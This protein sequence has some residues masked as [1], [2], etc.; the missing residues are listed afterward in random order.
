MKEKLK[1]REV[2]VKFNNV[3]VNALVDR[4]LRLSEKGMIALLFDWNNTVY[5]NR[6]KLR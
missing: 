5:D 1:R 6:Q 4:R 2:K 3:R